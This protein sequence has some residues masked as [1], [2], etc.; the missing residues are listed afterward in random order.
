MTSREPQEISLSPLNPRFSAGQSRCN[1]LGSFRLQGGC[2]LSLKGRVQGPGQDYCTIISKPFCFEERHRE[3]SFRAACRKLAA[4][5]GQASGDIFRYHHSRYMGFCI[6]QGA[7]L[8]GNPLSSL[9]REQGTQGSLCPSLTLLG[10]TEGDQPGGLHEG[11][12]C[13]KLKL[14][15]HVAGVEAGVVQGDI[16]HSD[17]H[18]LQ[19]FAPIPLQASLEGALHLLVAVPILIDLQVE[20]QRV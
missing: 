11:A 14:P 19:V 9:P 13:L 16:E 15:G 4:P 17:G 1:C 12:M 8:C 2:P 7:H 18:V 20:K 10:D 3:A 6:L 5:G